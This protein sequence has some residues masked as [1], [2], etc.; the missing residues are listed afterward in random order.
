MNAQEIF[1][2]VVSHLREQG[3]PAK[4]EDGKC[5]F[6][7][8]NGK[9]C[10]VGCLIPDEAYKTIMEAYGSARSLLLYYDE[11]W[12]EGWKQNLDLLSNLQ[13]VHDNPLT[14]NNWESE[15]QRVAK[16]YKIKYCAP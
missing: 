3:G 11:W 4:D 10:A 15:F 6:R 1:D 5:W 7:T 2:K 8:P 9:K 14:A 16:I 13:G 12:T